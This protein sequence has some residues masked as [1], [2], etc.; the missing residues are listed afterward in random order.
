MD[1][2]SNNLSRI[3]QASVS[4]RRNIRIK[5]SRIIKDI[6]YLLYVK[7]RISGYTNIPNS[8][9]I[10]VFLSFAYADFQIN[11]LKRI[12]KPGYRKYYSRKY[13]HKLIKQGNLII[14]STSGGVQAFE[15]SDLDQLKTGGVLICIVN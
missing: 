7:G 6:L 3:K 10:D 8:S 13:L 9:E 4:H 12:S 5:A 15:T 1:I 14:V 11:T 2:I